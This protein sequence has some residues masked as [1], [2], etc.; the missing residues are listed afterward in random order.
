MN[1]E[2]FINSLNK[3]DQIEFDSLISLLKDDKSNIKEVRSNVA[4]LLMSIL[5][6]SNQNNLIGQL[7]S[8]FN[9]IYI[10]KK[11]ETN[12]AT[13]NI[14]PTIAKYLGVEIPSYCDGSPIDL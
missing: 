13:V 10:S 7:M 2:E 14:A 3:E 5:N 4:R 1:I 9:D 8:Q 11:E 6:K 12:Q